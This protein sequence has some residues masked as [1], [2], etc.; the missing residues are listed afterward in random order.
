MKAKY[1][2][3]LIKYIPENAV[4][5]IVEWIIEYGIHLKITK[6]R[7]T[8]L[9]D[10]RPTHGTHRG[11]T[12]TINYNLNQYAFLITL[13]HEIAH[14][15]TWNTHHNRVRPHGIE[16]KNE[17]KRLM[18]PFLQDS[19]FP[20]DVLKNVKT[21]INNPAASSCVDEDLMRSLKQFDSNFS[22]TVEDLPMSALFKLKT[23][24]I[25]RKGE[26]RRK[27]FRCE[28]IGSN[29]HYLINPLAEV[30]L[31]SDVG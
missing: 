15:T 4:E 27:Y 17:F 19:I 6:E 28:E 21:Y 3:V 12:I 7:A 2:Q 13:I 25:F 20:S 18:I 14:F 26:Q 9:G 22:L 16:W 10:F 24:R 8:K 1:T 23:G 29:K 31:I 5:L 11:H 30:E